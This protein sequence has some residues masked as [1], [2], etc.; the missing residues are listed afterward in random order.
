MTHIG[1]T[2]VPKD[3]LIGRRMNGSTTRT[4]HTVIGADTNLEARVATTGSAFGGVFIRT[5]KSLDLDKMGL[6]VA[7]ANDDLFELILVSSLCWDAQ[8]RRDSRT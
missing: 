3:I 5:S 7:L 2:N 4:V 1:L 6:L 8:D